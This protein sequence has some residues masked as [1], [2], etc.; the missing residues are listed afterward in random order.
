MHAFHS[1]L[2]MRAFSA[3]EGGLLTRIGVRLVGVRSFLT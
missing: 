2:T 1:P 3:L